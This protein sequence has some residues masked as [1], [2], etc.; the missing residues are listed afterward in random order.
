FKPFSTVSIA[1]SLRRNSF[2]AASIWPTASPPGDL[3]FAASNALTAAFPASR[4]SPRRP[5]VPAC[6]R[7]LSAL[8]RPS[9][10]ASP[11]AAVA[12]ADSVMRPI[13]A[14]LRLLLPRAARRSARSVLLPLR[15]LLAAPLRRR[16]SFAER[17]A[18]RS[19][20]AQARTSPGLH[21]LPRR[22][23]TGRKGR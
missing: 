18:W 12:R 19:G 23:Q 9:A 14:L 15:L 2:I 8:R 21:S 7:L 5:F 17:Q 6:G 13:L 1:G 4:C 22:A 3:N 20:W 11:I 16:R 10:S